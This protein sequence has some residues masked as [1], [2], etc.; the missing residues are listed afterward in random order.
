M[1]NRIREF[2]IVRVVRLLERDRPFDGTVSVQ[3]PPRLGDVAT[4]VHEY[5]AS[6]VN[7][8][9]AVEMVDEEGMT[10]WLADFLREE[11]ELVQR[12]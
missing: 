11:L 4:V 12:P 6:H 7:T 9:V 8:P 2:D 3:R 5:D 10:V 1:V